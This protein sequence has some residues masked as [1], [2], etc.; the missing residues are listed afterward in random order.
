[1][2][3]GLAKI[4]FGTEELSFKYREHS[5]GDRGV[6]AQIF[7]NKDYNINQWAQGRKLLEYY[8]AQS[9]N[10]PMLIVDAGANIGA[11]VV[12][13]SKTFPNSTIFSIEPDHANWT[14][15]EEN[16]NTL[17][18]VFNFH[19][20]ISNFDG[21]LTL[22]DPGRSDWGFVTSADEI[23]TAKKLSVVSAISPNTILL[24]EKTQN[25]VPFILK[26]DIEGGEETL[27]DGDVD[28]MN[29]FPL[30]IIELHDWMIPFGGSSKNFFK[31]L[32]K[33]DFD[34]VHRGENIFL[35]N[36]SILAS[37]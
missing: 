1:M 18:N 33:F 27:F 21:D 37:V 11:S 24:H 5:V 9:K 17:K 20:A 15:L 23:A 34:F 29:R 8:A 16:T 31:A 10:H 6:I 35:F 13:F 22:Y 19:G 28:W 25:A 26:I 3:F 2:T 7:V 14:L 12:Y 32:A 36:R 30:V 4:N